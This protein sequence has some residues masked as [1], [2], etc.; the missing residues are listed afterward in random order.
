MLV[1]FEY[2][3]FKELM[4]LH[5]DLMLDTCLISSM[6]SNNSHSFTHTNTRSHTHK[7]Y[8]LQNT[9]SSRK[10]FLMALCSGLC[11]SRKRKMEESIKGEK[12][13]QAELFSFKQLL[14]YPVCTPNCVPSFLSFFFLFS[15]CIYIQFYVLDLLYSQ[16]NHMMM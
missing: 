2:K 14:I 5:K 10:L 12:Q 1:I 9:F 6:M 11:S 8:Q 3:C 4:D 16:A 7:T 15:R 13:K